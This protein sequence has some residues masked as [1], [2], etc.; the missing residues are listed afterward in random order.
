M[1]CLIS[2]K[3]LSIAIDFTLV[4]GLFAQVNSVCG[5][6]ES[7]NLFLAKSVIY[8]QVT[9]IFARAFLFLVRIVR[10]VNLKIMCLSTKGGDYTLNSRG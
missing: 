9:L 10:F 3:C 7:G 8:S 6:R 5:K 2:W 1:A 4:L